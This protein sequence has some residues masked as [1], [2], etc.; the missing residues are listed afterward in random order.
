MQDHPILSNYFLINSSNTNDDLVRNRT[1]FNDDLRQWIDTKTGPFTNPPSSGIGFLRLPADSPIFRNVSDPSAGKILYV[2]FN[3]GSNNTTL[4]GPGS[5]H[6]EL[7]FTVSNS[8]I[9]FNI[10]SPTIS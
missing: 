9:S 8:V 4:I 2:L 10:L 1:I 6:Y 7:L 3:D 5:G